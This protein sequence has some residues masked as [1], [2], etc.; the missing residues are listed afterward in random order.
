M[1]AK[2]GELATRFGCELVGDPNGVVTHV[3]TLANAGPEAL[4]FFANPA[5]R[6]Q[7]ERTRAGAVV[8]NPADAESCPVVALLAEDAYATYARI[9]GLLHPAEDLP[10]GIHASAVIDPSATV[11]ASAHVA[12]HAVIGPESVIGEHVAIGA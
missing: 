1:R 10:P 4:S 11:A 2:L 9:A 12:P 3:A 6:P 7:L 8:L 5:Y